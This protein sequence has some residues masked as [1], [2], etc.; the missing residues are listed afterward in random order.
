M[1]HFFEHA[2]H[3]ARARAYRG[4]AASEAVARL[5]ARAVS[6]G[7][8]P[9]PFPPLRLRS[10][11]NN[12]VV[13][14]VTTDDATGRVVGWHAL[15]ASRV[16]VPSDGSFW[17]FWTVMHAAATPPGRGFGSLGVRAARL[18]AAREGV[19]FVVVGAAPRPA[20]A[21]FFER[22]GFRYSAW[23]DRRLDVVDNNETG[24]A[25]TAL[26]LPIARDPGLHADAEPLRV[27]A[28]A[29]VPAFAQLLSRV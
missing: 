13:D 23:M 3:F 29:A 24:Y 7:T 11:A 22:N 15:A 4:A 21:R 17:C 1:V 16:R 9:P 26:Y 14:I 12:D 10:F 28:S 25:W 19:D 18:A 2:S 27:A 20:P 5:R 8:P 6:D